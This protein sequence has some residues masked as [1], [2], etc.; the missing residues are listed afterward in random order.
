MAPSWNEVQDGS[1]C[2][3]ACQA[4]SFVLL[5]LLLLP[6]STTLSSYAQVV[7][8]NQHDACVSHQQILK[9]AMKA[10]IR[11]MKFTP[12]GVNLLL[13]GNFVGKQKT[14]PHTHT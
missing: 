8:V 1:M 5:G 13:V 3:D 6:K 14:G 11:F 2:L 4:R 10:A 7:Q 9:A 12:Q